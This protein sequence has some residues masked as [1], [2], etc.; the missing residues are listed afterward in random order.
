[1]EE[2]KEN[3]VQKREEILVCRVEEIPDFLV[4]G[5]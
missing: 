4:P 5:C 2:V 3:C 1:M